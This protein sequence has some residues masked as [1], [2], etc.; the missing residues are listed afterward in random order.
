MLGDAQYED[1][2]ESK[3]ARSYNPSWGRFLD[4][5]WA[6]A[7]GS[8]DL[9]GGAAFYD[10]FG[11]RAGSAPYSSFSVDI[12]AWH[13]ISLTS[14]CSN[15]NV[16]GCGPGS[17]WHTWLQQD[18]AAHR[19]KCTLAFFHEPR[20]SSGKHGSEDKVAPYVRA[21]YEG[22]ADVILQGHDHDYE[23]FA[24]QDPDANPDADHGLESFV[25][26][27]GGK[28]VEGFSSSPPPVTPLANSVVFNRTTFGVLKMKLGSDSYSYEFVPDPQQ[29]IPSGETERF[30]DSGS[31]SCHDAPTP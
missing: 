23:R 4:K 29:S 24:P 22:G 7:G 12:G 25:V 20:W 9:Y 2:R 18:L 31:R 10:Y 21:L 17:R 3:I 16:G 13:V 15:A 5:T 6:T 1:A 11:D 14:N 30:T 28:S 26:G 19:N 8:H 27:T